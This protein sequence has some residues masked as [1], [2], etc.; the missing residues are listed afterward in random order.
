MFPQKRLLSASIVQR[1]RFTRTCGA[2]FYRGPCV[3]ANLS[4]GA[5]PT[6]TQPS[7]HLQP[8][9]TQMLMTPTIPISRDLN[10]ARQRKPTIEL[11]PYVNCVRVKGRPYFYYHPGR[12]TSSAG[13]PVRL[14][15][16]PRLPDF[17]EKYRRVAGLTEER[18]HPKSFNALIA[19]YRKS[20]EF[21]QLADSTRSDYERYLNTIKTKWGDLQVRGV[22]PAHVLKLRDK[23][24]ETRA[25]ANALI[26]VLSSLLSWSIPRGYRSDNPCQHVPKLKI[27]DGYEP[28]SWDMIELL[29]EHA[30]GWMW[31]AA[32]LALYTGQR[33]GDVLSMPWS[34]IK[35]GLIAV[36][37]EKTGKPLVIPAHQ[38]LLR[39][40][41][42]MKR[43]GVCIL[44]STRGTPWTKDGFKTSWGKALRPPAQ[45]GPVLPRP[46]PL[47]FIRRAGLVFHG[48]RK[49][50]VVMLLEAGATEA[51]VSAI[52]GQS[53]QMVAH[54]A[55]QVNKHR[56][57]A[58][59]ILKWER[60]SRVGD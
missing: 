40:L 35:N 7:N 45:H 28:W 25:A 3:S 1:R 55:K 30:P 4:A 32:A 33:Q 15:D 37:Q 47:W 6:S 49:S 8:E 50:A 51:E 24:R 36:R 31:Q 42:T 41:E 9:Q 56:L 53:L 57:A 58:A 29:R 14:P 13:K 12:G 59:G 26:R 46:H 20:P 10:V 27:G 23:Y 34:A 5:G 43:S 54:Y 44:S 21:V 19:D 16:D 17:W 22:Q 60:A 38:D 11:P 18:E 48:L 39:V 52:T 2:E